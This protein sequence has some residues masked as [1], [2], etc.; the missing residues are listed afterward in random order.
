M[1]RMFYNKWTTVRSDRIQ[2]IHAEPQHYDLYQNFVDELHPDVRFEKYYFISPWIACM[3]AEE[4]GNYLTHTDNL[5]EDVIKDKSITKD[6]ED[7]IACIVFDMGAEFVPLDYYYKIDKFYSNKK[8]H[9][10]VKYWTMFENSGKLIKDGTVQCITV[11][12]STLRFADYEKGKIKTDTEHYKDISKKHLLFLN[13]RIRPHRLD[14]LAKFIE[15]DCNLHKN[16]YFSLLGEE[17]DGD[18]NNPLYLGDV[19]AIRNCDS[20]KDIHEE[21]VNRYLGNKLPYSIETGRDDWLSGSNLNRI[22]ELEIYR[23]RTYVEVITEFTASDEFVSLSE[24]ISQAIISHQPF[25]IVG[26]KG[27]LAQLRNL[28][29]KTFDAFWDEKYDELPYNERIEEI[30]NVVKGIVDNVEIIRGKTEFS[31]SKKMQEVLDFN[32]THYKNQYA[33]KVYK[34][35]FQSISLGDYIPQ[36]Q[37]DPMD[38]HGRNM[39]DDDSRMRGYVWYNEN[40]NTLIQ[41]ISGCLEDEIEEIIAPNLGYRLRRRDELPDI[42]NIPAI[43][44]TRR[45]DKRLSAYLK[46]TGKKLE[47][48]K[49]LSQSAYHYELN[50]KCVI[51]IDNMS[52]TGNYKRTLDWIEDF[53]QRDVARRICEL[54]ETVEVKA[55]AKLTKKQMKYCD[56]N[57]EWDW[58]MYNEWGSWRFR[59]PHNI[60]RVGVEFGKYIDTFTDVYKKEF[61]KITK[62]SVS[63]KEYFKGSLVPGYWAN[64]SMMLD[65]IGL[66]YAPK[67][68]K[69]LDVGTH[70]GFMPHF[71]K[72]QGFTNVHSTNSY[73]EAGDS[74]DELKSIWKTLDIKPPADVHIYPCRDFDL[75]NNINNC[76][77]KDFNPKEKYDIILINMSNI[78]W[79]TDK[80]IRLHDGNLS[81]SWEI[82]DKNNSPNTFFAPYESHDIMSFIECIKKFLNV[83]GIAVV[84]PYPWAYTDFEGFV[85]EKNLLMHWQNPHRGHE[86]PKSTAHSP[87]ASVNDYFIVQKEITDGR[88]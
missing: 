3:W 16:S 47:E 23:R 77:G 53:G 20:T 74:I 2:Q 69:I 55:P 33:P 26:D 88:D 82:R 37:I 5:I 67:D 32:Y 9:K 76:Y 72:S 51:D 80:I 61:K 84:Q 45:P 79:K 75:L 29:F 50:C 17:F 62:N 38:G 11:S 40:T 85:D 59:K 70:F 1:H 57:Y 34:Y 73:K 54:L 15:K 41:P 64:H 63:H 46:K 44:F 52:G 42:S 7:G 65:N 25:I 39:R 12:T 35:A 87:N 24:K 68:I 58:H 30:S 60:A 48:V 6:L 14:I 56:E 49:L 81:Q 27:Y 28:G 8:N 78:F 83:G 66:N 13:K 4:H 71:L 31:Y 86:S 36:T 22:E 18:K 10:N 19:A 43:I 21:I